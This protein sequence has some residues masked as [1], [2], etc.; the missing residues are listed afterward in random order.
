[1]Q[2]YLIPT[3]ILTPLFACTGSESTTKTKLPNILCI[4]CEDISPIIG[5]YGDSVAVT[6]NLDAF[7][8]TA[9]RYNAYTSI[10]VSAPSRYSLITG[11]YPSSDGANY[12][13]TVG[14]EARPE[15][16][17][18]YSALPP[19]GVKCYSEYLREIGYYCTNNSKTDYQFDTP[20][21][22]WD[23]DGGKAHWRNRAEG[24]PFFA[25]FN[26]NVTHEGQVW[27][28]NDKPL[29][30]NP[31][32]LV[33]PPYYPDNDTIRHDMAVA[34]SNVTEM[35]RQ[36]QRLVDELREAGEYDNT[37]IIWY[38]DNGGPLPRQKR[39]LYESGAK[40]PFMIHFPDNRRAGEFS[41]RLIAFVDIP[42]TIMS[43]AGLEPKDYMQGVP[44]LGE[45][46]GEERE[47]VYG[48]KNRM[49]ECIDKQGCVRDNR[50]RYVRNYEVG[51]VGYRPVIYRTQMALMRNLL[52]NE[53]QGNLDEVQS[54]WFSMPRGKEEFYDVQNDPY[55]LNN[56][57][58]NP[59]LSSEIS[60][61]RT[62]YERWD[63]ECN[64]VWALS[65]RENIDRIH[66][67]GVTP[68]V[69]APICTIN[70]GVLTVRAVTEGSSVG[71]TIVCEDGTEI[72]NKLY[73]APVNLPKNC[74]VKITATRIGYT[75]ITIEL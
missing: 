59:E 21:T 10:G 31:D 60:R 12:M 74:K 69:E 5:C 34:Y 27:V 32:D 37:I 14:E 3:I 50:Y 8:K 51:T 47:Y 16:I 48:A 67:D 25:I 58:D 66:P 19:S 44:F 2:K 18:P 1:M 42:A 33:L 13:R 56:L 53:A 11:R 63:K 28:R 24:Q 7:S 23:E 70:D 17:E 41:D 46:E 65:E 54:R 22:A 30:V 75:P 72:K 20:I 15:G 61:L 45:F 4:V 68:C 40:V 49:D 71:Y 6:P 57:I 64:A 9:I 73:T 35:D 29:S 26:L 43:L 52:E 36:F 62:E 55:E 38:S 39:E